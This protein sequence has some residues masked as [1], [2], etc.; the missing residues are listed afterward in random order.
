MSAIFV[1]LILVGA[2]ITICIVLIMIH[3]KHKRDAMNNLLKHFTDA[4]IQNKLSF[5]GQELLLNCVIGFDGIQRKVLVVV[6]DGETCRTQVIDMNQVS[7]CSV[8][9]V[10]GTIH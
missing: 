9:K 1:A 2:L 4:G 5:S 6:K 7:N 3:N 10:Y 8:K